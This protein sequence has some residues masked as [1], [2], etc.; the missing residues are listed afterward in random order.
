MDKDREIRREDLP[1][2][3]VVITEE[4]QNIRSVCVGIWVKTGSR[5]EDEQWNGI[6]HFVEHMVFKGTTHRSAEEI[7]RQVD[8][9]GGHIDPFTA[10]E[11][12]TLRIKGLYDHLPISI[13]VLFDMALN[14]SFDV[15][16]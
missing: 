13:D 12:I 11:S 14:P 2:E 7:A 5:D 4:M 6:S 3:L 1:N 15:Q 9:I 8:C 16:V 10:K